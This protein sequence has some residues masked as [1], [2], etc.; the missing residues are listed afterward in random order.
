MAGYTPHASNPL[1]ADFIFVGR[2]LEQLG[3]TYYKG[4]VLAIDT[5]EM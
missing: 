3:F 2:R 5:L 4:T 1:V